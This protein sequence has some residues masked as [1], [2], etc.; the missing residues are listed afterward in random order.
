[1]PVR[2]SNGDHRAKKETK[3]G[4]KRIR[5]RREPFGALKECS[6]FLVSAM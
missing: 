1:M 4:G 2:K 3:W 6:F 5:N